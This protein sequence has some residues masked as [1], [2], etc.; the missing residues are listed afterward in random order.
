MIKISLFIA[1]GF[2]LSCRSQSVVIDTVQIKDSI[3]NGQLRSYRVAGQTLQFERPRLWE[4]FKYIPDDL[5][6][7]VKFTAKKENLVWGATVLG[8]TGLMIVYDQEMLDE[9]DR[10]GRK[11]GG[12]WSEDSRYKKFLGLN[13]IPQ[14]LSSAVYYIGNGGTTVLLSGIFYG[15]GKINGNDYRALHT[16]SE[17]I[18]CL[19]STGVITQNDFW[20]A[21]SQ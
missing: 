10:L 14:N 1:F 2:V 5:Y 16:S 11:M 17:L 6:Q 19:I 8:S 7:F 4:T 18:E 15:I 3:G 13:I 20:C 9:A 21:L 12:G